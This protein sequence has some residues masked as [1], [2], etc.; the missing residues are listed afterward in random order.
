MK[1]LKTERLKLDIDSLLKNTSDL[2]VKY[3]KAIKL[4]RKKL[5]YNWAKIIEKECGKSRVLVYKVLSGDLKY[6]DE[7]IVL[8]AI[9]LAENESRKKIERIIKIN[10]I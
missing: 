2:D 1:D 9:K 5:P 10:N 6:R 4:L 3:Q 8:C 7:K